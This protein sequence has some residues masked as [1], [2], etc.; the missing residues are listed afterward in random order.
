MQTITAER[1][2]HHSEILPT[3]EQHAERFA[4]GFAIIDS[5][6]W[7]LAEICAAVC[8][9]TVYGKNSVGEFVE[10]VNAEL[11][12]RGKKPNFYA[13][14]CRD[15]ALV[16]EKFGGEISKR[17]ENSN[18]ALPPLSFSHYVEAAKGAESASEAVY[19]AKEAEI[20]DLSVREFREHIAHEKAVKESGAEAAR[21]LVRD[22]CVKA[23]FPADE[24][25]ALELVM[26]YFLCDTPA[27]A[28]RLLVKEKAEWIEKNVPSVN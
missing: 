25:P 12:G 23:F 3:I 19:L 27:Q 1:P 28:V 16:W 5:V 20:N 6:K 11:S 10:A 7:D 14:L 8:N 2:T 18:A 15:Y 9:E 13:Q 4:K 24:Q 26:S 21:K 17:L 22:V